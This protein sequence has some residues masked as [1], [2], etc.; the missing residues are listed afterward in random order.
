M[1]PF[2]ILNEAAMCLK[3]IHDKKVCI[4]LYDFFTE[5]IHGII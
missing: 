4:Q 3:A 2:Q 5:G 1:L